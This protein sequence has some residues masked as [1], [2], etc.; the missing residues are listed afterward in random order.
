MGERT[1][2]AWT[3]STFNPWIGC[4]KISPGCEACYAE[5]TDARRRFGGATHWGAGVPRMRTSGPN[6]RAALTWNKKAEIE[7]RTGLLQRADESETPWHTPGRWP[8]FC[9]SLADVFDNEVPQEW[10]EDLWNLIEQTTN[11]EWLIVTKR[12]GSAYSMMPGRWRKDGIPGHVRIIATI[13]NKEEAR[14]DLPKLFALKCKN[15]VSYEPALE[16]VDWWPYL[17]PPMHVDWSVKNPSTK[18]VAAVVQV[19]RAAM[20]ET[21]GT[22]FI[23]WLIVG[24]ESR[25]PGHQPRA[26]DIAWA[27][28]TVK[29]CKA[30]GVPVFIKQ[31]GANCRAQGNHFKFPDPNGKRLEEWPADLQLQE[32]PQ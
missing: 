17:A 5:A 29:Q 8:V 22:R 3:R 27:R 16:D 18:D 21:N 10:R 30:A 12:I 2:I 24:G 25:Q 19:A 14:R 11:L 7:K 13:V 23:D 28:E 32:F 15:G 6:W 9:A 31:M 4:T 1:A 20:L 26:F